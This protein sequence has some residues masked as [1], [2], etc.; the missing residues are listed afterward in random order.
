MKRLTI[1][2]LTAGVMLLG[3]FGSMAAAQ[4]AIEETTNERGEVTQIVKKGATH[5]GALYVAVGTLKVD[6]TVNG[7]IYC[8]A[9]SELEITGT[10]NGDV[11]CVGSK[12]R[13]SGTVMQDVRL[14]GLSV[15]IDG[16]I[17]GDATIAAVERVEIGATAKVA[18]ELQLHG[19]NVQVNGEIGKNAYLWVTKLQLGESARFMGNV[20]YSA[21][22]EHAFNR[23]QV[24]GEVLYHHSGQE[25]DPIVAT[26]TMVVML[27][28]LAM[29][30]AV[31]APRFVERSSVIARE[32]IGLAILA[33][34]AV[35]F[36]TPI[37]A[38]LTLLTIV[39]MPVA[40]VLAALYVA[41]LLMSGAFFA[42]FLGSLLFK[43]SKNVLVRMLAGVVFLAALLII[44]VVNI[45]AFIATIIMGTGIAVRTLTHNYKAP[46]YSL[47]PPV[48]TPPL[49][50][51][52]VENTTKSPRAAKHVKSTT[53]GKSTTSNAEQDIK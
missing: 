10:V 37:V 40:V 36:I 15:S 52:L 32:H 43:Q 53:K 35:V 42:Y 22:Q 27:L 6:G 30:V 34:A 1:G 29:L 11:L 21:E 31:I 5:E 16:K 2:L 51:V 8:A 18:G 25:E 39:G 7:S 3:G 19:G 48:P 13:I 26:I 46:R 41:L 23:D 28:V 14:G 20:K 47:N 4:S 9:G 50:S 38:M 33:G 12:V 44:P 17:G 49:P 45:V 24:Q